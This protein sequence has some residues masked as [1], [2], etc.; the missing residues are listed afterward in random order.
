MGNKPQLSREATDRI[1][2]KIR[3]AEL[4][5]RLQ[6]Y[7]LSELRVENGEIFMQT[8]DGRRIRSMSKEQV[9]AAKVLI[10]KVIPNL[11]S[12]EATTS[13]TRTFVLRAPPEA[14]DAVEWLDRYGP[15]TIEHKPK[16]G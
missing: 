15:K 2:A 5:N 8:P 7:A 11:Q 16:E 14:A 10:D 1:R 3:T 6:D 9:A 4:I 13:D 12:I